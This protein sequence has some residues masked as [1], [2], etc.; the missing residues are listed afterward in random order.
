MKRIAKQQQ[1]LAATAY[2]EA[3]HA[4]AAFHLGIGIGRK[5]VNVILDS[6]ENRAGMAH[7]LKGFV[8]RPDIGD[9]SRMR[10]GAEKHVVATFAGEAAQRKFQ[11]SSVR[12]FH[13][14]GDRQSAINLLSYFVGDTSELE[15]YCQWLQI[16]AE[17]LIKRPAV[18][19]QVHAVAD[20]LVKRKHLKPE[21]VR[22]ICKEVMAAL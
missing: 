10:F 6:K 1:D 15:A 22:T 7:L 18:W 8:G 12:R 13:A 16:R 17:N 14:S 3:G 19:A 4:V 2:H 5:G 11:P 9:S 20:A 21:E